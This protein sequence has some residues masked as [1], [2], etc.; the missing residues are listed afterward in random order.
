M[1]KQLPRILAG[2]AL[3]LLSLLYAA[4]LLPLRFLHQLELWSYDHR[5]TMT[6][7]ETRDDR[8]VIVDIDEK[9]LAEV[10]R[11]PWSRN[12]VARMVDQLFDRYQV[13]V[14]GFDVVFA[15]PDTSSGIRQLEQLA[16]GPLRKNEAFRRELAR[17]RDTLDY[18]ALL[19]SRFRNRPVVLGYYF[20]GE[21]QG[22][23]T[24]GVLPAPAIS[25]ERATAAVRGIAGKHGYGANIP[26]LQKAAGLGGHFNPD[27]DHDGVTRRVPMLQEY[28]GSY[29]ESL[30]LAV[31]RAMFGLPE[32]LPGTPP[33]A[34][35]VLEWLQ[36][37]DL[38][39][40]VDGRASALIPYRGSQGSF[41]YISAADI[42]K[43]RVKKEQLEGAIVLVGTTAP[44]LMDL[45]S[46][47]VSAVYAGVEIHA[48]MIAGILDQTIRHAPGY[49][50]GAELATLALGGLVLSLLL[51]FLG[52]LASL[53]VTVTVLLVAGGVNWLAWRSGL[54]LPLASQMVLFPVLYA[55]NAS[56]G[57]LVESR[58]RRQI[59]GLFGQYVP[60]EIVGV[61][62]R[63]PEHFTMEPESREM[64]VLFTDVVGFTGI[65]EKLTPKE[66][67]QFMNEY[68]SA[69]TAIIYEYGGTVDKYIGDAIMAFWGAPLHDPDH[70]LHA[71]QAATAMRRRMASLSREMAERGYPDLQ[72]GVGINSGPMRVGNMGSSYRVAYTVMGDAV[73][74]ASR[75]EGLTRQYGIWLIA[76]QETKNRINGFAWRELD[77]VRVKGKDQPV[78]I[79]EPCGDEAAL[80]KE[81]LNDITA[82][83][84]MVHAY[85]LQQ[86][87]QAE[88]MLQHL[89][90]GRPDRGLY[91]LYRD[92]IRQYR[93][94]PPATSWDGVCTFTI[95]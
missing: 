68:L 24:A 17:V 76:G 45:R 9:S 87:D 32:L 58:S 67:A 39:I 23:R 52:P 40:P 21:A 2:S 78:A 6:M 85:R 54:V 64:T 42:L 27:P 75:L 1:K 10:G 46:T 13:A 50:R 18:D 41:P 7:P 5:L 14:V 91:A 57:F 61:M 63:D 55:F 31:L 60:P 90:A 73:N 92:R 59:T 11:W 65:S 22:A 74:L 15:E 70:A 47:P 36:V 38:R 43:G 88:G 51:P 89:A 86:W 83:N 79:F 19:A 71:V 84:E 8:I 56:Y 20:V 94:K 81:Y 3:V 34:P 82:F 80:E 35:D 30:S 16:R 44:G 93:L 53:G 37:A 26:V 29:Y 77:L 33:G 66:L 49:A 25:R 62:S 95:K 72:I 4:G 48:T 12:V 28:K 69:M